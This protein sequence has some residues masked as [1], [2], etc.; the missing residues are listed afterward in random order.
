TPPLTPTLNLD[1]S[2]DSLPVGDSQTSLSTV[3]LIGE[4]S[5]F[6]SITLSP[7]N[8]TAT[9]GPTG[10]FQFTGVPLTLGDNSFTVSA[11]DPL[12]RVTQSTAMITR[13]DPPAFAVST[14]TPLDGA[15]DIGV[16]SRPQVFFTRPVDPT[17][18][19]SNNFFLTVA[20]NKINA[21]IVPSNDGSFAW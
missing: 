12:H 21:N 19:N 17:T 18:L 1:A 6:S 2:T 13:T 9:A 10:V 15:V 20:G 11:S 3:I 5:P 4:A 16:T 8:L 7:G 14:T